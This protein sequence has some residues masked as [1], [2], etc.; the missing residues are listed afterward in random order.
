MGVVYRARDRLTGQIVALKRVSLNRHA[1]AIAQGSTAITQGST[2]F[3]STAERVRARVDDPTDA[4]GASTK[5]PLVSAPTAVFS[6]IA[7]HGPNDPSDAEA[8]R[9]ALAQEFRAL[10]SLHHPNIIS[11]L[12]YGF[13]DQ[14]QPYITMELL[15]DA[16]NL[17]D[18]ASGKP[19]LVRLELL[20]QILTALTYLHRREIIHRDAY[21]ISKVCFHVGHL[22]P[23]RRR[24][25]PCPLT[26][27]AAARSALTSH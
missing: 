6:G 12:D 22:R 11:V 10:A 4:G 16:K 1:A 24:N 5:E 13:D 15:E 18:F 9:Q 8:Q 21:V 23:Q 25:K 14:Q 2:A 17:R 3:V 19:L 26:V 20:R 7:I 27:P